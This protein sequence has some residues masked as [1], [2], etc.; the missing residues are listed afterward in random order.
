MF[1]HLFHPTGGVLGLNARNLLYIKPYN[2]RRAVAFADDKRRTKAYLGSRGIPVAKVFATIEDRRALRTFD[3][4]SLPDTCVLKPNAGFGGEGIIILRGRN[5]DGDFLDQ[6]HRVVTADI[7]RAHIEDILDGRFSVTGLPDTAFFEKL[8]EPDN[9]F[10]AFRPLGLPDIRIIVFNLVPVMAM[11]RVPTAES[12][13]KANVHQGGFG[14]GID[15]AK[16]V[17]THATQYNRVIASLPHGGSPAGHVI[18][19]WEELLLIASRIQYITNIGY[20][21]VDLTLDREQGPVLLE[22]NARAGLM[23]QVANL[24]PL[25]SRLERVAGLRV[26]SPEKG[27]RLAQEL[28]GERLERSKNDVPERPILGLTETFLVTGAGVRVDIPCIVDPSVERSICTPDL[29]AE[30]TREGCAEPTED[31]WF[32]IKGVLGGQ[33][34]QTVVH[35][36]AIA[37]PR[38]RMRIG[39]RD[40]RGF[41]LDP[42]KRHT[43]LPSQTSP[44]DDLRAADRLLWEADRLLPLLAH[45]KPMN[46]LQERARAEQDENYAPTFTYAPLSSEV[47]QLE[48]RLLACAPDNSPLGDLLNRKRQELL[49]RLSLLQARGD[50]R[51][52]SEASQALFGSP[53]S[54]LLAAAEAV[55]RDQTAC[56]IE[57]RETL[58]AEEAAELFREALDGYGLTEWRVAVRSS[59]VAD[60]AVGGRTMHVRAG[61]RFS[62][63]HVDSLIAH[64]IE[65]HIITAENGAHQPFRIFRTGCANYLDTQEGLAVYQQ[66]RILSPHHTK[67][68]GPARSVLAVAHALTHGFVPLRRYLVEELGYT[69]EKALGKAIIL[70]RGLGD[71]SEHGAFTK[72][73]VY[74]RGLRAIEQFVAGGGDVRRI[75]AGRIAL[76]DLERVEAVPGIHAPVLLPKWLLTPST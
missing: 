70:K 39:R 64:E 41:L 25:R 18:P 11:L 19:R 7:L 8:L 16:G 1:S 46:L 31:G 76:E 74:L 72:T 15:L 54:V 29:L 2:P 3:F 59:I 38:V 66:N 21:A 40:I 20:L 60:C 14:I 55:L 9:C 44:R 68:R 67:R 50:A 65:T 57:P 71:T 12:E 24:A 34:I 28:F 69:A 6:Q 75:F 63:M 32:R 5:R 58:S 42:Q 48:Q 10:T 30:L 27:V 53:T 35:A 73:L 49:L 47:L 45:L 17:T 33:K 26:S 22:V 52:F 36:G 56:D 62:R 13:G 43:V 51:R 23:V 61:A 4:R 37:Q